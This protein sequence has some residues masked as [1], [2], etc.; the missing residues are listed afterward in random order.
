MSLE[1]QIQSI[2]SR[3]SSE[4]ASEVAHAVRQHIAAEIAGS[5]A[6]TPAVRRG[7]PKKGARPAAAPTAKVARRTAASRGRRSS[8]QVAADDAK[9]LAYVKAHP[10]V[11][12]VEMQK[13]IG[14]GS[15]N[16][17][18]GLVRLRAAGKIK[19][20]GEWSSTT[21]TAA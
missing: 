9:I 4:M 12:S 13:E 8:D 15:Q 3:F 11:R 19:S 1:T 17:A 10:G 16:V 2:V 14:L 7:R 18:S 21:Y 5:G 20:K 6:T